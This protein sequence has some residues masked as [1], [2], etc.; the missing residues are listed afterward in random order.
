MNK[1][2]LVAIVAAKSS[3][4]KKD[5]DLILTNCFEVITEALERDEKVQITGFGTYENKKRAEKQGRNPSTGETMI[6]PPRKAPFLSFSGL[7]K[8]RVNNK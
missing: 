4:T 1:K 5:T 3:F 2:E 8:D 7:V 6:H